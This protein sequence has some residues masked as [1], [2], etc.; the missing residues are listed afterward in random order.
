MTQETCPTVRIAAP[1]TPGGFIIINETDFDPKVHTLFAGSTVRRIALRGVAA[2]SVA[3]AKGKKKGKEPV[4]DT[5]EQ[6][7]D[8]LDL[9]GASYNSTDTREELLALL[10]H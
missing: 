8:K 9:L 2:A 3:K 7:K 6:I 4:E 5:V 1:E 10:P